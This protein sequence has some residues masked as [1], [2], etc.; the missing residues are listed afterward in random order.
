[1][2]L[3]KR[4][5]VWWSYFYKDGVRHQFSTGTANKRQAETIEAKQKEEVN[6][7]R[8]QIVETDRQMKFGELADRFATSGS[9]RKHHLYHLKFLRP[10]FSDIP[11]LRLTKSLAEEFR[12]ARKNLNPAIKEAT[13]NRDLSVL[14]HILYWAVD[15]QLLVQNPLARMK[16]ARERRTRRQVLSV[17][18]E[19]M[20]LGRAKNHLHTMIIAAVDTGMRRGEITSQRWEDID[21][22]RKLVS[23]TRSKTPEG[24]SREI[25]L[26]ERLLKLLLE[27][28]KDSG[29]IVDYKGQPVRNIK[30]SW[31]TAL[32][33]AQVRHVRFHDLRHTFNTRLMEAGVLQEIRM[34]L[35]G[36]SAGSKVHATYT[37]IELPAK[38]KAIWKLEQWVQDQLQQPQENNDAITET[39]RSESR[40]SAVSSNET[41]CPQTVEEEVAR[42]GGPGASRQAE[43]RDRRDGR[44]TQGKAKAASEIR[45]SKEDL[46][47]DLA[48]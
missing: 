19:Q 11:V 18:E 37:H 40:H 21:F 2:S 43:S 22:S 13:I 39:E 4:G 17:A 47:G 27:N 48:S 28:R 16:M 26:T 6:N 31:T 10:C 20:L 42:R 32:K 25:P 36:H 7:Q 14:R 41:G 23:V 34:T 45:R 12:R 38:R 46:R 44:G 30:R 9:V 5:D 3:F 1:V 8:F 35:M 24:E 15:E 29:L 33:N